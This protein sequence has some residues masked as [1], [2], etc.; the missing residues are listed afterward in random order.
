MPVSKPHQAAAGR[1]FV[2]FDNWATTIARKR[3]LIWGAAHVHHDDGTKSAD[4]AW[5]P[6]DPHDWPTI[7]LEVGFSETQW[8]VVEDMDF[9]TRTGVN[10]SLTVCVMKSKLVVERWRKED[11]NKPPV[12][13]DKISIS[14]DTPKPRIEGSIRFAFNDVFSKS[15]P[16]QKKDFILTDAMFCEVALT[17]WAQY[18]I[19]E[20]KEARKSC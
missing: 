9:W 1:F 16:D 18:D 19:Y 8:K 2:L 11:P 14:R 5:G 10:V 12:P 17:V 3:L 6:E 15:R 13:T 7:A 4:A 20:E